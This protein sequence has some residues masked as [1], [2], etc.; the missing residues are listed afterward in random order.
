[1]NN[2]ADAADQMVREGMVIL[3]SSIKLGALGAKNAVAIAAALAKDNPKL[4]GKT[5][6]NRLL[7]DGKEL[8][9]FSL[10]ADDLRQ[11]HQL[12]KQYGVLYTAIKEK[13]SSGEVLSIMARAEDVSKLNRIFERMGYEMPK[14]Q[15]ML[16][17]KQSAR[18]LSE[19]ESQMQRA[20]LDKAGQTITTDKPSIRAKIDEMREKTMQQAAKLRTRHE[21]EPEPTIH[22]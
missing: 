17:K 6:V 10:K 4:K 18:H 13:G 11:F 1:M 20:G 22:H 16:G 2:G 5:N 7:R 8:K 9:V 14:E 21:K 12:S 3:E 19:K 15:T